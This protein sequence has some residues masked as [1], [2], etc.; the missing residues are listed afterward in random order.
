MF[1]FVRVQRF[2]KMSVR[3]RSCSIFHGENVF[4][5]VRLR[6]FR[7]KYV[8]VFGIFTKRTRSYSVRVHVL[9]INNV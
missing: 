4:V 2:Q 7:E 3:V 8:F 5:F 6:H 9:V 1:V